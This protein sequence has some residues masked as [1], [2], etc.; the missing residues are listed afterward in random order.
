MQTWINEIRPNFERLYCDAEHHPDLYW[1]ARGSGPG[2][3]AVVT[4]FTL[5]IYPRPAVLGTC[6]YMYPIDVADEVFSWGRSISPEVDDRVEL[7]IVTTRGFPPAGI[8]D[9]II[10]I[11]SPV[12]ADSE[13]D[14]TK[15]LAVLGTCPVA[16]RAITSLPYAPTTL[17]NWYAA[18]MGNYPQGHRYIADNMFIHFYAPPRTAT[19][20]AADPCALGCGVSKRSN[21]RR[22][23]TGTNGSG[24]ADS[25]T[26]EDAGP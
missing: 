19:E 17:A 22:R 8:H 14:A 11:A 10:T 4:S 7:Q 26:G 5:R 2:F 25:G 16:D 13:E 12:F 3:F 18:V 21:R 1:A 24:K 9:P 23:N 20:Y 15:A 6:L